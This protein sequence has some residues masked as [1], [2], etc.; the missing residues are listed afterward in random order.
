MHHPGH[1]DEVSCVYLLAGILSRVS[2]GLSLGMGC[3]F[4]ALGSAK[5]QSPH[6]ESY[7]RSCLVAFVQHLLVPA[8]VVAPSLMLKLWRMAIGSL[9]SSKC[10]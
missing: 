5:D 4:D 2:V 3:S 6:S 8:L 7:A 9:R 10:E 1:T